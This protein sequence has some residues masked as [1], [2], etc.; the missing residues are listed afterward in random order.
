LQPRRREPAP[1][2]TDMPVPPASDPCW[3]RLAYGSL[4]RLKTRHLGTQLMTKRV[5]RSDAP[6]AEKAAEIHAFFAKWERSLPDE[7]AQIQRCEDRIMNRLIPTAEAAELI[8]RG[9]PL[10]I[11]G[12]ETALQTLPAGR[13]IGGTIPYF[14]APGGGVVDNESRVFVTELPQEGQLRFAHYAAD[15]L[16][17]ITGEGPEHGF[18]VAIIPA[19]APAHRRFA[20]EAAS[21]EGAFLKPT[22]GWIAGVHLSE[23]GRRAP[24]VYDGTQ[25]RSHED[26]GVVAH[27]ALPAERLV[28]L[29]IVNIFEPDDGDVLRFDETSFDVTDC[30]V[31]GERRNL[32]TY[33]AERGLEHG[34]QPL[35]G[36]FAGAHINVAFQVVDAAAGKVTL[37]APVFTGVEYRLARPIS[38]YAGEF[39]RRLADFDPTGVVFS[40]NCILNFLYGELEGKDA[41]LHGPITFG[42]I[43]Y[44]L[45]NQTMAVLRVE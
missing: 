21:Y 40:C 16:H 13:W 37:F 44:Q 32:A 24:R 5:E 30:L 23:L 33:L 11:A 6:V 29:Q 8:R 35:V 9:L 17:R 38:D 43:G 7:L 27:V 31:N 14:M 12:P 18:S 2:E 1:E 10:S 3:L 4:S 25:G 45:L 26:G 28:S 22:I 19:M 39:R 36:D 15:E 41:G 34:R 42:E 20:A